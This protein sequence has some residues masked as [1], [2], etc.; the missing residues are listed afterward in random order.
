MRGGFFSL[1]YANNVSILMKG[2][3]LQPFM[4]LIQKALVE[5]W[6]QAIGLSV[7]LLKTGLVIFTRKYKVGSV[8]EPTLRSMKLV[9]SGSMKYLGVI[10]D[11][12]LS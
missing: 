3:F 12:K 10:P 7:N 2:S 6:Y 4:G 11:A 9:L 8:E 1:G 5:R